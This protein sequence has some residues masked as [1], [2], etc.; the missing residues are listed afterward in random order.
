MTDT[1]RIERWRDSNSLWYTSRSVLV[2][3]KSPK[4][5]LFCQ[6]WSNMK[7]LNNPAK[8]EVQIKQYL[9][10]VLEP[11]SRKAPERFQARKAIAKSR[12]LRLQSCFIH[13]FLI[14][15]EVSFIQEASAAYTFPFL[16]TD[17]L[18]NVFTGTK[19]FRDFRKTGPWTQVPN[20]HY[21]KLSIVESD[22]PDN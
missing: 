12:T 3:K 1:S 21:S 17:K 20:D 9:H 18:K 11:V 5:S 8:Y 22:W 7:I 6:I 19:S 10:S 16:D 14:W 4:H 13:V 15:T 2:G